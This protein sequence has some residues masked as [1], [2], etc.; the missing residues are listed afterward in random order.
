MKLYKLFLLALLSSA[1]LLTACGG[2]DDPEPDD[3]TG[4]NTGDNVLQPTNNDN[5]NVFP[6]LDTSAV[7]TLVAMKINTETFVNGQSN[8]T[9]QQQQLAATFWNPA[10]TDELLDVGV[11]ETDA[12][13][14]TR[15]SFNNGYATTLFDFVDMTDPVTFDWSVEG[16]NDIPAVTHTHTHS[17]PKRDRIS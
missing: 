8:G 14:L 4:D 12:Y 5:S 3:N 2:D 6:G 9:S 1:L 17:F 13:T 16:G 15:S 10:N 11:V 7:G